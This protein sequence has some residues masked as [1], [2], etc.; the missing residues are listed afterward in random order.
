MFVVRAS[1]SLISEW[2]VLLY[3]F[4]LFSI[5]RFHKSSWLLSAVLKDRSQ[6]THYLKKQNLSF[7]LKKNF[8]N[9][10]LRLNY[11][12]SIRANWLEKEQNKKFRRKAKTL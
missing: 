2:H 5:V 8:E 12:S 9:F 11:G 7:I 1:L 4:K 10:D 3:D 6:T